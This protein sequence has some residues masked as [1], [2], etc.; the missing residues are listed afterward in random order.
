MKILILLFLFPLQLF[1]Q[2]MT[3]VWIGYLQAGETKLPYELVISGKKNELDG[4]SQITFTFN[5]VENVG[6]KT[7]NMK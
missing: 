5:G 3:G 2:D 4:Y 7:M 6:I 1:S